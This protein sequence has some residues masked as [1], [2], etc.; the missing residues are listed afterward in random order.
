MSLI[1]Q[2]F[3]WNY[4]GRYILSKTKLFTLIELAVL[5]ITYIASP[6]L[7]GGVFVS[8]FLALITFLLGY[9][10]HKLTPA[11]SNA[12]LSNSDN[13]LLQDVIALFFF[14]QDKRTGQYVLSKTKIIS[15]IIFVLFALALGITAPS[16]I[17][18]LLIGLV[19]A[20][21]AFIVGSVI[22]KLTPKQIG[23]KPVKQVQ[24]PKVTPKPP[25]PVKAPEPQVP[26][27]GFKKYEKEINAL[28][29]TYSKKESN[30]RSLIEKKFTPPQMTYDKFIA[31]VDSSSKLFYREADAAQE[32]IDLA[33][34]DSSEVEE[35]ILSK[36]DVLKTLTD[37]LDDL[38]NELVINISNSGRDDEE[39]HNLIDDME[40]LI[41]SVKNYD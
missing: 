8:V 4:D 15:I 20:V 31:V 5:I 33:S 26:V 27:S 40:N 41:D 12:K 18:M 38:A 6:F 10:V 11:P 25:E 22:H 35:E 14:W 24:K 2:L 16:L 1:H 9:L 13:G 7:F 17:A 21:P 3:Y 28:K 32:M 37:K 39:V 30:V 23:H 34:G 36:I 29:E 19:F